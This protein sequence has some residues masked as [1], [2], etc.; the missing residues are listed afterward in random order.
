MDLEK[1]AVL[2]TCIDQLLESFVRLKE[3]NARLHQSLAQSSQRFSSP[4]QCEADS[5]AIQDEIQHLRTTL[6]TLQSER[7][8]IRTQLEAMLETIEQLEQIS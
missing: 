7:Q 5:P 1:F 3:E 6:Q 4:V 2:E 8:E